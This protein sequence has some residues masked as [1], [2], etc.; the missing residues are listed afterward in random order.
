M[1]FNIDFSKIDRLEM[2]DL[3][4][5]DQE[6]KSVFDNE[7]SF[8]KEFPNFTLLLGFS[9]K[10]KFFKI[11]YQVSKNLNFDVEALQIDLPYEE[12]VKQY[13]CESQR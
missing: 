12:D 6:V 13:W 2:R 4:I 5:S 11:A 1:D 10:R 7:N 9:A 3:N 8:V